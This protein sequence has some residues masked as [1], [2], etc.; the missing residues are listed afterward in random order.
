MAMSAG[1]ATLTSRLVV[2]L[3]FWASLTSAP[4]VAQKKAEEGPELPPE[5][6]KAKVYRLPEE[7]KSGEP[8]EN[9]VIYR[10]LSY[11]DINFERLVLNLALSV[12]PVDRAATIRKIYFQDIRISGIP[13]HVETFEQEFKLS[14]KEVVEL[15]APLKCSI[16]FSDLDSLK[17]VK[18]IVEKDKIVVTGQTFIEVKLNMLEKLALRSKQLVLPVDLREE[19]PLQMFSGNPFMQMAATKVL[20]TL[21]DPSSAAAIALAREHLGKLTENRKLASLGHASVY[22]LYCEYSLRNPKT[23]T[24]EKFSQSGTGFVVSTEGKLLTAK[25][26]I[27][28]WKFDPQVAFLMER[29]HLEFNP[30]SYKLRAWPVGVQVLSPNGQPDSQAA[31]SLENQTLKVLKTAPDIMQ[32]QD[33]QDPD[34]GE[35]VTLNLHA[36]GANDV[37]LLELVGSNFQALPYAD[38]STQLGPDL[39]TALLGFPF[40]LTRAQASPELVYVKAAASGPLITLEHPLNP[41]ESGAPLLTPEGKVLALAGGT[42]ECIPIETTRTLIQ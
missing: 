13:V 23:Q 3:L 4:A 19:V 21:S 17:P 42:N 15:P 9:P 40:G 26:V 8:A 16:V 28:P 20:E 31:S 6:R 33:Y 18:E 11:Q 37:A 2:S 25:R 1:H 5:L 24:A 7:T 32:K 38:P 36:P 10:N 12:K 22:L 35:R 27:Q 14:K 29:Y 30:H 39:K 34:S 41:G